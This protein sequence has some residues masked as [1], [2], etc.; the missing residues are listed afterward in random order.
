MVDKRPGTEPW[1]LQVRKMIQTHREPV[2]DKARRTE[3]GKE[4]EGGRPAVEDAREP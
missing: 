4:G 3:P 1:A 2:W